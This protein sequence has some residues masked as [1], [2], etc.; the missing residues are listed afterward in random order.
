ML[1]NVWHVLRPLFNKMVLKFQRNVLQMEHNVLYL[2]SLMPIIIQDQLHKCVLFHA[3]LH[4]WQIQIR[5]VLLVMSIVY[6]V[7]VKNQVI[8]Y[9]KFLYLYIVTAY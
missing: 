2:D 1:L 3:L 5:I 6:L 4:M 8:T 7:C 9:F